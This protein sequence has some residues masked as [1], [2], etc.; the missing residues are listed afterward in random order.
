LRGDYDALD[1]SDHVVAFSRAFETQRFLCC[2]PRLPYVLTDGQQ[3]WPIGDAWGDASLRVP[4]SG[5]YRNL[6]TSARIENAGQLWLR[7]VFADFPVALLLL[8]RS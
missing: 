5:T 8:E 6:L 4:Y 2:V 7:E 3:Q 1:G